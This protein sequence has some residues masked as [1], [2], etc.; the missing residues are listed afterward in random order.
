M[1][2]SKLLYVFIDKKGKTL[3][4][5]FG[6]MYYPYS[7]VV[8]DSIARFYETNHGAYSVKQAKQIFKRLFYLG[9]KDGRWVRFKDNELLNSND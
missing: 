1:K 7:L 2:K 4:K 6:Y 9:R 3:A 5:I 8:S